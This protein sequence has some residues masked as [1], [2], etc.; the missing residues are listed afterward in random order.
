MTSPA[1]QVQD[2]LRCLLVMLA[3][4][5]PT[6]AQKFWQIL[7]KD[8]LVLEQPWP[9]LSSC[10]TVTSST[11]KFI[12]KTVVVQVMFLMAKVDQGRV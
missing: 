8:S 2:A 7:E 11:S 4:F 3:P 5:A 1:D 12:E 10:S 9:K 6:S